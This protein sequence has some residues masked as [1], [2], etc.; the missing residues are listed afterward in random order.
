MIVVDASV[1]VSFL[2]AH[3]AHHGESK[4]WI[5]DWASAGR[6][7]AVPDLFLIEIGAA[8]ARRFR[9]Q[10][11]AELAVTEIQDGGLFTLHRL[12]GGLMAD[13]T[14]L[15][16]HLQLR[17]ADAV[18]VA[19]AH[20]LHL[21]LVTWDLEQRQRAGAVIPVLNPDKAIP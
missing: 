16:I 10:R 8:I 3:D 11:S 6:R 19:L 21:P 18:Y 13:A 15:A 14:S 1:W 9:S 17:A 20:S 7:F 5:N 2:I 4:A 12:E